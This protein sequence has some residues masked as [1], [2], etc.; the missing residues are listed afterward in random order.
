MGQNYGFL[1]YFLP[2]EYE[3]FIK[4]KVEKKFKQVTLSIAFFF[5]IMLLV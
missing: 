5:K 4:A 3:L 1:F 2:C